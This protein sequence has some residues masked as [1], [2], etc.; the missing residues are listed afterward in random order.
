MKLWHLNGNSQTSANQMK[1]VELTQFKQLLD[2]ATKVVVF[3]GAGISTESGIPDFRGPNGVWKSLQPIDFSD[4]VTSEDAR[5]LSWRRKFSNEYRLDSAEPNSGHIAIATLVEMGKVVS[6]ITQ[7]VDGLHQ[8]SGIPDTQVIEIHGNANYASCLDCGKRFE[9][10]TI[11]EI[12]LPDENLPYCDLCDG[13]IKTATISFGQPMPIGPMIAAEAAC[14]NSDLMIVIG[15]SLLVYPAAGFP[16][17]A[18]SNGANL[19]M[20]NNEVTP[21][22]GIFDLVLHHPIGATLSALL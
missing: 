12:F 7:N 2:P 10:S 13:L 19:I 9:L 15:T 11:A 22:D 6:V 4:F 14:E 20:I 17:L 3:T 8:K 16:Q 1:P 21:L 18:L 5:R